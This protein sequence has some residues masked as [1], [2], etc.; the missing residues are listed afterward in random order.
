M[1]N[2]P[3]SAAIPFLNLPVLLE[4]LGL[5]EGAERERETDR[6]T[7]AQRG[8]ERQTQA[9]PNVLTALFVDLNRGTGVSSLQVFFLY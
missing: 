5:G 7:E 8:R 3:T 4:E 6:Q 9:R 2:E 1:S